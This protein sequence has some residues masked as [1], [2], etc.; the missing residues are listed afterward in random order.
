[1]AKRMRH[2]AVLY[3]LL[4]IPIAH[5]LVFKYWPIYGVQIAFREFNPSL[6]VLDSPWVGLEHFIRFFSAYNFGEVLGN[7]LLLSLLGLVFVF[8]VP[9]LFALVLNQV[10]RKGA[11]GF[12]QTVVYA[13]YFI[14]TVVLVG[15]LSLLLSPSTGLVNLAVMAAGGEPIL[16]LGEAD[17][18][19]PL[20]LMSSVWQETGF[21][22]VV[23]LAALS[24]VD[25][26]MHEAAVID[27]A[28]RWLRIVHIDLPAITPAILVM[29]TL[30][31]GNLLNVGFEK[32][33]LMQSD[34][35]LSTS[36]V[37]PTY[38][39]KVGLQHGDYSYSAA[40][41]LFNSFVNM[42]LLIAVNAFTKKKYGRGLY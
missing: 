14:S 18:F 15:M 33:F 37:L 36:E 39:Y 12:I 13:P 41:G 34:L 22:A 26:Q 23:Y 30:A 10:R 38:I 1:M 6:G 9:V 19:R 7:T 17:W 21:S 27:G 29:F 35:N 2:N 24:S 16:F 4:A 31:V 32:A 8:P 25:P 40:I 5:F 28:S 3:F 42:T 20:Y 11:R